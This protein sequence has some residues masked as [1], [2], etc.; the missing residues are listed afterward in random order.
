MACGSP[1]ARDQT[2]AKEVTQAT[3]VTTARFLNH[4]TKRE[5]CILTIFKCAVQEH[6]VNMQCSLTITTVHLQNSLK[7]C[8]H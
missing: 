7:L 8:P 3:A 1:L 2:C 5:L 6:K 4:C